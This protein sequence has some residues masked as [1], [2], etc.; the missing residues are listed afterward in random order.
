MIEWRMGQQRRITWITYRVVNL[1]NGKSYVGMT[2]QSLAGRR[3]GHKGNMLNKKCRAT[4]FTLALRKYGF[5]MFR[6]RVLNCHGTKA[7]MVADEIR[8]IAL[9]K[10]EYNIGPGG[11]GGVGG[12]APPAD[13][14]AKFMAGRK[15][16]SLNRRRSVICLSD[17]RVFDSGKEAAAHYKVSVAAICHALKGKTASV[18]GRFFAYYT[19]MEKPIADPEQEFADLVRGQKERLEANRYSEKVVCVND[20]REFISVSAA[21]A[22]YGISISRVSDILRGKRLH[23]KGRVFIYSGNPTLPLSKVFLTKSGQWRPPVSPQL[24]AA[25]T[26]RL[27]KTLE[28]HKR[29]VICVNDGRHF[30]SAKEASKFYGLSPSSAAAVARGALP[31]AKGYRFIHDKIG[32]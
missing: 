15:R 19:G 32:A 4:V 30:A 9:W 18:K 24:I 6:F 1:V 10:P 14:L 7:E 13:Q 2:G 5:D 27:L 3:S 20:E 21:A 22:A 25:S 29:P 12:V 8:L 28:R 11:E 23:D 26:A 16:A 31:H 17:G